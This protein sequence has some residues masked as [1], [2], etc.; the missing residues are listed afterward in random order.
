LSEPSTPDALVVLVTGADLAEP[1]LRLLKNFRVVFAGK[2][3][4][5]ADLIALMRAFDPI[6]IIV[7]YGS[8]TAEVI[9]AGASLRVISKHGS[10]T[11]TIDK[12]AAARRGIAV[13]AASGA[14]AAAVA[15][16]AAALMLACAKSLPS[17][18]DRLRHGHWDKASHK[19]IELEG[20]T[21]GLVGLG[22][23]GLRFA[24][25]CTAM[26]MTVKCHDPYASS[27]PDFVEAVS[28]D[29]LWAE[30]DVI[31]LHC[32]LTEDNRGLIN[33]E[34][35]SQCKPGAILINT[36]RG[37]LVDETALVAALHGGQVF[38]AGL[39]TF[40]IEPI[41]PSNPFLPLPN[42]ILSPH[43]GGVTSNAYLKMGV[44][45]AQNVLSVLAQ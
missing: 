24:R 14:N 34:T 32:P 7:R 25:I 19:S 6:A 8:I 26:G 30:S 22:A 23:I 31:S 16:H 43:V 3:P 44:G 40:A 45:A 28:L 15:E 18:N 12:E 20:K 35:L 10:G 4:Q 2:R 17:L 36:A 1:A 11:D 21:V 33:Q 5:E 41:S 39:D 37:G 27:W 13:V 29:T 38:A 42:A 9:D